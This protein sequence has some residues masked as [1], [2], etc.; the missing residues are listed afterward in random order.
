M[1]SSNKSVGKSLQDQKL[2]PLDRDE[3]ES[4]FFPF[5]QKDISI[6]ISRNRT[7]RSLGNEF[8]DLGSLVRYSNPEAIQYK[9]LSGKNSDGRLEPE[10]LQVLIRAMKKRHV[11]IYIYTHLERERKKYIYGDHVLREHTWDSSKK[12]N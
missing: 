12:K 11:Y 1:K 4:T 6:R 2:E 3:S 8:Q 9:E 7:T 10:L 5:H